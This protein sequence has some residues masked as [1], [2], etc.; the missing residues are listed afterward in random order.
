[1]STFNFLNSTTKDFHYMLMKYT[2]FI[3]RD[4]AKTFDIDYKELAERYLVRTTNRS[5]SMRRSNAPKLTT[6]SS[7]HA[8]GT[9]GM[10]KKIN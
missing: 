9:N 7:L 10:T 6:S 1:M 5:S 8:Q 2:D 4:V 3:I